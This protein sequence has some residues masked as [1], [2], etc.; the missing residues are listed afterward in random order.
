M[1]DSVWNEALAQKVFDNLVDA[2]EAICCECK[3]DLSPRLP[4]TVEGEAIPQEHV[5]ICQSFLLLCPPCFGQRPRI[6]E[7]CG[8]LSSCSQV[9]PG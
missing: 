2:E 9:L 7:D 6:S 4:D 1:E 3:R 5:Q 8:S